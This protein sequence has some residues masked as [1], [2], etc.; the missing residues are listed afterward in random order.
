M[1]T[2]LAWIGL[3]ISVALIIIS[4]TGLAGCQVHQCNPHVSRCSYHNGVKP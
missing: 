3:A 4:A 1:K 2:L